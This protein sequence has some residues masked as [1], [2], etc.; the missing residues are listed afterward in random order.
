MTF[1]PLRAINAV[2][3]AFGA[4]VTVLGVTPRTIRAIR[5]SEDEADRFA[6]RQVLRTSVLL[7]IR[8]ADMTGIVEGSRLL[9]DGQA[10]VVRGV[11][12]YRD[13]DR[14]VAVVNTVLEGA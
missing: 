4:G 8:A 11:P 14:L 5:R 13:A 9:V 3:Q 2:H 7:E 10:R 6:T 1:D 12:E